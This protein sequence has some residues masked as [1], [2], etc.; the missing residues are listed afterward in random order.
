MSIVDGKEESK[1]FWISNR[2]KLSSLIHANYGSRNKYIKR[3]NFDVVRPT[4]DIAPPSNS[5]HE[6]LWACEQKYAILQNLD[7]PPPS[8][9]RLA[10]DELRVAPYRMCTLWDIYE[11]AWG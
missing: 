7:L 3:Q 8:I 11:L 1:N 6:R 10:R 2:K 5:E 4:A 9:Y